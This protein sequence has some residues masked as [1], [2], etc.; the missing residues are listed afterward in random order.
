MVKGY[1]RYKKLFN[2]QGVSLRNSDLCL[3]VNI[4]LL[5]DKKRKIVYRC[6]LNRLGYLGIMRNFDFLK[7]FKLDFSPEPLGIW[8]QKD[9]VMTA[10]SLI[11]GRK[12]LAEEIDSAM[13]DKILNLL[14]GLY[15]SQK[16]PLCFDLDSW[17]N[18]LNYLTECY[19]RPWLQTLSK[20]RLEISKIIINSGNLNGRTVMNTQIHGDL[21]FRN[22]IISNDKIALLDF[23]RSGIDFPEFDLFL[24]H[25]DAL[26]YK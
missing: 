4:L 21:T 3:G 11:P 22:T 1:F 20:I 9:S 17:F 15:I 26:I 18:K 19:Q 16:M 5:I 14:S 8:Q 13:L 2:T 24:L 25:I 6:C 12:L 23:D 7:K 10:E